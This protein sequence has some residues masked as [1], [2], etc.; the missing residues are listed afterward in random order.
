M[1]FEMVLG[2]ENDVIAGWT[3]VVVVVVI[4]GGVVVVDLGIVVIGV[5]GALLVL[6]VGT[7]AVRGAIIIWVHL[8]RGV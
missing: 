6:V 5:G 7:T 3:L 2:F 8:W 1:R 4:I